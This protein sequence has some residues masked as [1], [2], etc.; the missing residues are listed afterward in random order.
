MLLVNRRIAGALP[1]LERGGRLRTAW[2]IPCSELSSWQRAYLERRRTAETR[3]Q[4]AHPESTVYG[5]VHLDVAARDAATGRF[6]TNTGHP[7]FG[8]AAFVGSSDVLQRATF[9]PGDSFFADADQIS[10]PADLP[11]ILLDSLPRDTLH[12]LLA[13]D[14][15]AFIAGV[16]EQLRRQT[17]R[18]EYIEAQVPEFGV[19][20]V[21]EVRLEQ[22]PRRLRSDEQV[23]LVPQLKQQAHDIGITAR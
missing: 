2:D 10:G 16:R 11:A 19:D 1:S 14:D 9:T 13:L 15:R 8:A 23:D 17:E 21:R 6:R 12:E 5:S 20:D 4:L 22:D 7:N 18:G 3:L